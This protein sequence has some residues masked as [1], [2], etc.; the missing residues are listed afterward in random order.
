MC[1]VIYIVHFKDPQALRCLAV[2]CSAFFHCTETLSVMH[3]S[4]YIMVVLVD[5]KFNSYLDF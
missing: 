4:F 1:V 5:L 2:I 3:C